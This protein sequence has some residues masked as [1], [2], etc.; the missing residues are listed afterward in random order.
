MAALMEQVRTL[1]IAGSVSVFAQLNLPVAE[2]TAMLRFAHL[3]CQPSRG[4]GFGL[5]PLEAR[6]CGVPV[7]ATACTGHTEHMQ[8]GTPGVTVVAHGPLGPIDDYPGAL[9]PTVSS[10]DVCEALDRAYARWP[11]LASEA[12]ASADAVRS[13]WSWQKKIEGVLR[14]LIDECR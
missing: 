14:Y 4:E 6:A 9:A 8:T 12:Q 2:L 7:V 3:V 1:E 10:D 13:E 11:E 5:V